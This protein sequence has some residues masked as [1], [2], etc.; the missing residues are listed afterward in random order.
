MLNYINPTYD[1]VEISPNTWV[2]NVDVK[3][4][5]LTGSEEDRIIILNTEADK[6]SLF[7]M[8]FVQ[9]LANDGDGQA[10]QIQSLYLV[11]KE[12]L[13][14]GDIAIVQN[15][16]I[17]ILKSNAGYI[18][19]KECAQYILNLTSKQPI[20]SQSSARTL[21]NK[22]IPSLEKTFTT[23]PPQKIYEEQEVWVPEMKSSKH[24]A[25]PD[26][27]KFEDAYYAAYREAGTHVGFEDLGT[28][29]IL[30][31][32]YEPKQKVWKWENMKL[33]DDPEYDLRDPRFF[34]NQE[35]KL[36]LVLGGSFIN[37]KNETI[38]MVPHVATLENGHWQ[39]QKATVDSST[40]AINGQ[41]IWRVTWN[42]FDKHGYAFSYGKETFILVRTADGKTFEKVADVT[43]GL[44]TDLSEAT[45]RFKSD[46]TAVALIRA[47][48]DGIIG[49][50]D[51]WDGYQ[52]WGFNVIPFRVGGPN[53][54]FSHDEHSMWAATRYFFLHQD[55]QLDEATIFASMSQKELTPLL[56]LK[57]N[58]DTSYPGIV[59]EEDGSL[60]VLYY[61]STLDATSSLYITRI[62]L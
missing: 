47:R 29:R 55:N 62:F 7:S 23:T 45:I 34:V 48:R 16:C 24:K 58:Y 53:F 13:K 40:N 59:L 30:K 35:N 8:A 52:T 56:R 60:T 14:I 12:Y 25:F 27:I 4:D 17:E 18:F 37:E 20:N 61:S 38:S 31:G 44:L 51:P 57:S 3:L 2:V 49:I 28:I 43:S 50:S 42:S 1:I 22:L 39:L 46:G 33:L 6:S 21:L 10:K 54:V 19:P 15:A 36:Q 5:K 32:H 26:L 9:K 41:W 11:Y